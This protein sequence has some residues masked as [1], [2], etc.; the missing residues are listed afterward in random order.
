MHEGLLPLFPLQVVLFPGAELPL[1]IFEDRYK[2]M[3]GEAV[4]DRTEFGVVMAS[5]KGMVNTGCT[6]T[7]ERVLKQYPDGRMD[8]LTLGRRR[9]EILLLNSER[10][11]LRGSVELFDDEMGEPV[12]PENRKLALDGYNELRSL[13][14]EPIPAADAAEWV[15]DPRLSF[16]LAQPVSELGLRQRLLSTRSEAERMRHLA[17]FFPEYLQRQRRL[18]HVKTIAPRNGHGR[19][20]E[21]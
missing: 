15:N 11:F 8:I 21:G 14:E 7:V 19:R 1:H 12:S 20:S 6:A 17:E 13:S 18:Q 3:I 10:A 4:R 16:R 5:E 2:E 9:F